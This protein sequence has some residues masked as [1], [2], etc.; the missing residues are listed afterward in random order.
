M[1]T[2][3]PTSLIVREATVDDVPALVAMGQRFRNETIYATRLPENT[4]QMGEIARRLIVE[5]NGHVLVVDRDG[6]LVGTIG[7]LVFPHHFSGALTAAELFF[8]VNPEHRGHGVRLLRRAEQ[9]ARDRGATTMQMIA[10]T[11]EVGT[12]YTRLGYAALEVAYEKELGP[13]R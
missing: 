8:W 4:A 6:A 13:C 9:W 5:D 11:P 10:P 12:L 7:L 3:T 2:A 1:L